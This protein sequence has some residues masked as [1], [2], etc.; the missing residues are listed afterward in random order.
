MS[1]IYLGAVACASAAVDL[2]GV[3]E[4]E[5][6]R[7]LSLATPA[8]Q[9]RFLAGRRLAR[10]MLSELTGVPPAAIPITVC[11]SGRP[12]AEGPWDFSISHSGDIA[13]CAVAD[14]P[15]GADIE[16][17]APERDFLAIARLAFRA[18]ETGDVQSALAAEGR[19]AAAVRFLA[20]WTL[21]EAWLKRSEGGIWRMRSAP[22]L[23]LGG[24][25]GG[26]AEDPSVAL[27]TWTCLGLPGPGVSPHAAYVLSL[28]AAA[29]MRPEADEP[30]PGADPR[31]RED[32][33][34][35]AAVPG[36]RLTHLLA[37]EPLPFLLFPRAG[38]ARPAG[39]GG[40]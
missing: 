31:P 15:V 36:L 32:A 40:S 19:T 6:R 26:T 13:A 39:T 25:S 4:E 11:P 20:Y 38:A 14:V 24:R 1:R 2:A 34:G 12:V 18:E 3:S 23:R 28:C 22:A 17:V 33:R 5:R 30:R 9:R 35:G 10:A 27:G 16:R 37:E 8:A 21:K 7:A 29:E